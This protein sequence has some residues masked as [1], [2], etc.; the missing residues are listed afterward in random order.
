MWS[1][2]WIITHSLTIV[3]MM[4][5]SQIEQQYSENLITEKTHRL[6]LKVTIISIYIR[7]LIIEPMFMLS[8]VIMRLL[9]HN[10]GW[11]TCRCTTKGWSL[12]VRS[13]YGSDSWV[14]LNNLKKSN[15][16]KLGKYTSTK[17]VVYEPAFVWWVHYCL[18]KLNHIID[19]VNLLIKKHT[20]KYVVE[21]PTTIR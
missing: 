7:F 15:L 11:K 13:K 6:M 16:V 4:L 2:S 19:A 21:V 3:Y 8:V 17:T 10:S 14:A 5:C 9:I 18:K 1:L 12:C 20:H